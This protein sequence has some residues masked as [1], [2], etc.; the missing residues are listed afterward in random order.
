[1]SIV[2]SA[3]T[4]RSFR[5]FFVT[6]RDI[7][8]KYQLILNPHALLWPG[9]TPDEFASIISLAVATVFVAAVI[10]VAVWLRR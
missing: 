6:V 4:R 3:A 2:W 1:V 5:P 10:G 8:F 7:N 9:M